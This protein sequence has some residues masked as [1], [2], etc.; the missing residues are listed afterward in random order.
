MEFLEWKMFWEGRVI[1]S[2]LESAFDISTPQASVDLRRY[3]E[4]APNNMEQTARG[5]RPAAKFMPHFLKPSADRLLLQLRA[6]LSGVIPRKDIWF[7]DIPNVAIAPDIARDIPADCMRLILQVMRDREA[8]E[9]RYQSLT[10]S[11]RRMIAPHALAHDGFRW[12]V[13]AWC[14]ENLEFRDFVLSRMDEFGS[15]SSVE[16][17]SADDAAWHTRVVLRLRPHRGLSAQQRNAIEKDFGMTEGRRNVEVPACL[18]YYLIRRLNLDLPTT[19]QLTPERLQIELENLDEIHE[20]INQAKI[21]TKLLI[22]K[23]F[24]QIDPASMSR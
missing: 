18:A 17:D 22:A 5:Y 19:I 16:Y 24:P 6:F 21:H 2:D 20:Q 8:I 1:R 7:K 12:H 3:R 4:I 10:S 9:I 23:R 15:T 14:C 11:R 13:R